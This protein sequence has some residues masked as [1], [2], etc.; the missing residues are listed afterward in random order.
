VA[1]LEGLDGVR[2][3]YAFTPLPEGDGRESFL[4]AGFL[5]SETLAAAQR[6]FL[7]SLVL[8]ALLGAGLALLAWHG[9]GIV[10]L[11]PVERMV[12]A[13]R[14]VAVGDLRVRA[15]PP[16]SRSELGE[17]ARAVDE[18]SDAIRRRR[19][20]RDAA[21]TALR[22]LS[23]RRAAVVEGSPDSIVTLDAEGRIL[24]LNSSAERM[25]GWP[26]ARLLGH[27]FIETLVPADLR[28]ASRRTFRAV[29]AGGDAPWVGRPAETRGLRADG[30]EFPVEFA[31]TR[32]PL[33]RGGPLFS[34]YVRDVTA[35]RRYEQALRSLSLVDD[36]TGLYNRRGFLAFGQQQ[37]RVADRTG[38]ELTVVFADLDGLKAINDRFGH[39]EGDQAIVAAA[40]ALRATFRR[41]DVIGRLGGDEF[42]ALAL[43]TGPSS[44]ARLELRLAERIAAVNRTGR[45]PW[46]LEMSVGRARYDPARPCSMEELIARADE[47]MYRRK[48]DRRAVLRVVPRDRSA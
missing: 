35:R 36:L 43:E 6:T 10:V 4:A 34:L 21:E 3:V 33:E 30:G 48:R 47:A 16:Y 8:L 28:E 29:V 26:R 11:R 40:N 46:R 41:S 27:D 45:H 32:I 2:R 5:E 17:L 38:R 20:E 15:G 14:A 19:M 42:A 22:D 31:M 39:A 13:A 24:E 37:L 9:A 44:L 7:R 12:A 1:H 18:M 23:A 25:F